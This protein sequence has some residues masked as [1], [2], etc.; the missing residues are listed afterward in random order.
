MEIETLPQFIYFT[1][2]LLGAASIGSKFQQW[3]NS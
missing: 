1:L 3:V 2:A